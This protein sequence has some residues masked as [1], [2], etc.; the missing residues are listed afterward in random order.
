MSYSEFTLASVKKAFQLTIIEKA[1]IFA[2]L[3][4]QKCSPYLA[5]TLEYNTPLALASNTE[6]ARSELIITPILLEARKQL[7]A[8]NFFSGVK[9]DIDETQGLNGFCDY[10]I[11]GA[12]EKLFIAA[13]VLMMVEAKNENIM[14]GLGQC[15]AEMIAAQIFNKQENNL[16]LP[17]YGTVTTGTNWQ[18]LKLTAQCVEIDLSEYY[19]HDIGKILGFMAQSLPSAMITNLFN[20]RK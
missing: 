16:E 5:E 14:S 9:F 6:K 8:F 4:A 7:S 19:L 17:I 11:S 12:E 15:I 2:S 20:E 13:P 10:I 3:P 1:G 18:F